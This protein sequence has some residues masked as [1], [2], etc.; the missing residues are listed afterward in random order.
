MHPSHYH[1]NRQHQGQDPRLP[2]THSVCLGRRV[3]RTIKWSI[4]R[5]GLGFTEMNDTKK[6]VL[7]QER[8]EALVEFKPKAEKT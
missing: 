1:G 3:C 2:H 5:N 7:R 8:L 4:V 6:D